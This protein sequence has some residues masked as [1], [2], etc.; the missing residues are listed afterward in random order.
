MERWW[1]A[2]SLLVY[3]GKIIAQDSKED[4]ATGNDVQNCWSGE[5][6]VGDILLLSSH[7]H[8]SKSNNGGH[9]SNQ[10]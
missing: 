7:V 9:F 6:I 4:K 3:N 2:N 5:G 1:K 8:I 10:P